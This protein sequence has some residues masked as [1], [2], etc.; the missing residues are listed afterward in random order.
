MVTVSAGIVLIIAGV[1]VATQ[2]LGGDALQRT[3]VIASDQK[4][5]VAP[6]PNFRQVQPGTPGTVPG[7]PGLQDVPPGFN[8]LPNGGWM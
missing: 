8:G 1:W 4:S 2:I 5:T 7:A 3:G 6:D